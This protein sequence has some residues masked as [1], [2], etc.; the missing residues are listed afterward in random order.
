MPMPATGS[1][2]H[3]FLLP[4][5]PPSSSNNRPIQGKAHMKYRCAIVDDE[6]LA[7]DLLE[8]YIRKTA[9]LE[10]VIKTDDLQKAEQLVEDKRVDLIF[11]DINI[12]GVE[13]ENI[14]RLIQKD[15]Y[16]IIVTAYPLSFIEDIRLN[17]EHGYL[18]K[19]AS[20]TLF[21]NE[22]QRVTKERQR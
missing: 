15:C 6:P 10:L 7:L 18:S 5:L 21:L 8:S 2:I 17:T 22:V 16:F 14:T 13:R 19:P 11:L 9:G 3:L 20:F 4:P 1:R 12:R